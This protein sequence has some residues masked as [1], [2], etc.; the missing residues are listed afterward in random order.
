MCAKKSNDVYPAYTEGLNL[1]YSLEAEQAVLG[2]VLI[3]AKTINDVAD[4]LKAEH[5]YLPEHQAIY[6]VM[7]AKM[8][9]NEVI[10]IVTVLDALKSDGFFSGEE[11]KGGRP[12]SDRRRPFHSGRCDGRI[13]GL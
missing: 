12:P 7:I 6:R 4:K 13:G 8:M 2:S 1:P 11:G 5:F 10:D 9:N 3:E